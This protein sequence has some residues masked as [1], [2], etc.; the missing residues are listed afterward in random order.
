MTPA[1]TIAPGTAQDGRTVWQV[2]R[3]VDAAGRRAALMECLS[4][5]AAQRQADE[6]NAVHG[7]LQAAGL[8][9]TPTREAA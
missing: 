6:L 2:L 1:Y 3:I 7:Q 9:H 4:H 8:I 5:A